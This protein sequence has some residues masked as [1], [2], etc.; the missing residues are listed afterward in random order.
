MQKAG[1]APKVIHVQKSTRKDKKLMAIVGDN[2]I[3]FGQQGY[4][5]FTTTRDLAKKSQYLARHRKNEDWTISGLNSA[6]FWARWLLW[7]EPTLQA[8]VTA[9]NKKFPTIQ[10]TLG[11]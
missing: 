9:L 7:G 10:V 6:G 8:S 3:H 5:D 11:G 4:G 2:T 1:A